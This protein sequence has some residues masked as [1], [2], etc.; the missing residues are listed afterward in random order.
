MKR[1]ALV[2]TLGLVLAGLVVL[3]APPQAQAD[4]AGAEACLEKYMGPMTEQGRR[5]RAK[6]IFTAEPNTPVSYRLTL[7][8]GL[9]YIIMGCSDSSEADLD[10][11]LYDKDGNSVDLDTAK[12]GVPFVH[13]DPK[14]TAEYILQV[15]SYKTETKTDFGLAIL[16]LDSTKEQ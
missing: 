11:R 7:Y 13:A 10:F 8:K 1:F 5:F 6:D 12:D 2:G 3:V 4:R 14:E 9:S 16:Y 15:T